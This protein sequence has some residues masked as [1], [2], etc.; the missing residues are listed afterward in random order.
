MTYR[1]M[2]FPVDVNRENTAFRIHVIIPAIKVSFVFS[3]FTSRKKQLR[4]LSLVLFMVED[5]LN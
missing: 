3:K 5:G 2:K 1:I 4:R